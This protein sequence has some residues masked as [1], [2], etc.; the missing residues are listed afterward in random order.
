MNLKPFLTI[1]GLMA[2]LLMLL[3]VEYAVLSAR[4][5]GMLADTLDPPTLNP[6]PSRAMALGSRDVRAHLETILERPLFRESRRPVTPDI[7]SPAGEAASLPRLSGILIS[8]AG[9]RLI[10]APN[11]SGKSTVVAEGGRIG[12][13]VVQSITTG[14]ATLRGPDGPKTLRPTLAEA[15]APSPVALNAPRQPSILDLLRNGPPPSAGVPSLSPPADLA[16]ALS[17]NRP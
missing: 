17:G 5:A 9:K 13:Y 14:N 3:A 10:F 4:G 6:G 12:P 15:G 8:P 16:A 2:G 7:A 1:G 11:S